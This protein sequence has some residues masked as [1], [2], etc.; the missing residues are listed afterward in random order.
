MVFITQATSKGS[1]DSA[2]PRSLARTLAVRTHEIW[3]CPTKNQT[4]STTGWLC[5]RV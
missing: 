3:K 4:S 1:G 5:M 2:H